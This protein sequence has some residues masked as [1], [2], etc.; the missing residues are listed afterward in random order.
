ML[1]ELKRLYDFGFAPLWLYPNSKRPIGN[2]WQKGDRPF[3]DTLVKTHKEK[4]NVGVRLGTPSKFPDDTYLCVL[5][6]DVKS[7]DPHHLKELELALNS[8]CPANEFAPRVLSGRGGGSCHIYFR[9]PKPQQSFKAIRSNHKVKVLMPSVEASKADALELSGAELK[10]GYRMRLAWEVDVFGDGKQVVLP[11]SIHPDTLKPYQWEETL[12]NWDS[13]PKHENFKPSVTRLV[14]NNK[15][16]I[17]F[18]EVDLFST[19]ISEKHFDLIVR[20]EGFNNYPSRSEALFA[21]L[22]ALVNAGLSDG[23]IIT[24][25]TDPANF[26]S[27]KPLE[28]GQGDID[29]SAYW[30]SGQIAKIRGEKIQPFLDQAIIDDVDEILLSDA[31]AEEQAGELLSW[32]DKLATTKTGQYKNTAYNLYL[33]LKHVDGSN[34]GTNNLFAYDEFNQAN[35]Y[36]F[37]PPWGDASDVGKELTDLDDIRIKTWLSKKWGIET[38]AQSI[39]DV[40]LQLAKENAYHPVLRYLRGLKWDGVERLDTMLKTYCGAEGDD[41]YLADV[42]RKMMTACVARVSQPGVK[43]DHVLI[44]EGNQGAGK[45][46]F[47]RVL[48]GPWFTDALGDINS[49]DVVDNMR[50]K[51]IIELGELSQ[52]RRSEVNDLKAFV[53]RESDNVRKAY[54]RRSQTYPRQCVFIG[55]TNDEEYLKDETGGRRFWP[56]YTTN[57]DPETLARDRD[58]L[59]AEAFMNYELGEKLYLE[60]EHIRKIAEGEQADRLIVDEIVSEV[61]K[62]LRSENLSEE[63]SFEDLWANMSG[64]AMRPADYTTQ[65]RVKKAL[66]ILKV[67][68]IRKRFDNGRGYLWVKNGLE[69]YKSY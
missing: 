64:Y 45:S 18:K 51:W 12:L 24:V 52:M 14:K 15:K 23:Q 4:N 62:A 39:S 43:F 58:Q 63:F 54:G 11:P 47:V 55:T 53:T 10:Q 38:S 5:D 57:Y 32:T 13:I 46:T 3:W 19:P 26:M 67:K 61:S 27:E 66:R 1:E 2:D 41:E 48:A 33:I 6:V 29:K 37:P 30:L 31:E 17:E 44:L 59:W 16:T 68:K 7:S 9:T 28:A 40:T 8:F 65:L 36:C 34:E 20:G 50:G 25:L 60:K 21:S 56:V 35:C 49:K 69:T 22:N 42:G